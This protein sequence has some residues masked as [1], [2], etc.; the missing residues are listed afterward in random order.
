MSDSKKVVLTQSELELGQK[1]DRCLQDTLIKVGSG[2]GLGVIFSVVMFRR[3]PW[4]VIFGSGIGL[5]MAYANCQH[6]FQTPFLPPSPETIV[7]ISDPKLIETVL[8]EK[9]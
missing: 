2:I 6:D 9:K 3:R 1:W 5:G 7:K 4:P 8:K